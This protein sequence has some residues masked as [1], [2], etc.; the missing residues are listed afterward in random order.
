MNTY[1]IVINGVSGEKRIYK[2]QKLIYNASKEGEKNKVKFLQNKIINSLDAKLLAIKTVT[3]NNKS[4]DTQY[5]DSKLYLTIDQN[6][7]LLKHVN[8]DGKAT[9][10]KKVCIPQANKNKKRPSCIPTIID[11]AKEKLAL[12]ALEPE[13]EAIV[14]PSSYGFMP[15]RSAYDAIE[16]IFRCLRYSGQPPKYILNAN[17][18]SCFNNIDHDHLL[19]KINSTKQINSQIIAW[20][21][22]G[23]IKDEVLPNELFDTI[24]KNEIETLQG[25]MISPLVANIAL[26]GIEE[27]LKEWIINQNWKIKKKN[28]SYKIN[29]IKS[30][31]VIRYAGSFVVIHKDK[32]II[33]KAKEAL[34]EWFRNTSKLELNDSKTKILNSTQGIEFLGFSIINIFKSKNIYKTKIYPSK[35]NQQKLIKVIGDKCRQYRS[36]SSFELI[37]ILRPVIMDWGNYYKYCECKPI[38]SVLDMKIFHILRSWVFRRDRRNCRSIIKEKYFPSNNLYIFNGK[39]YRNNWILFGK[40]K[41]I[42][43]IIKENFLPK[44]SWI[45][46]EKFVSIKIN[47]SV[48]DNDNI[49]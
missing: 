22:D 15:G 10:V 17:L 6:C 21:K 29:E 35:N 32:Q 20:L 4:K 47:Y 14:E 19:S 45:S 42:N 5:I 26:H 41:S 34:S 30:L 2:L 24:E 33:E 31:C 16:Q 43:D 8:L 11:R 44:L 23:I 46:S 12:L 1:G 3:S 37:E 36:I 38:F 7:K 39:E 49:Y 25:R 48:Y 27:F 28:E 18:K 40:K 9:P 13:W